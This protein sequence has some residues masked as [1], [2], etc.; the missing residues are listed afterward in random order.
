M[1][2]TKLNQKYSL[3]CG[4][5]ISAIKEPGLHFMINCIIDWELSGIITSDGEL[6]GP[7]EPK[8]IEDCFLDPGDCFCLGI[9]DDGTRMVLA[10]DK[11]NQVV[12]IVNDTGVLALRRVFEEQI[13]PEFELVKGDYSG[14]DELTWVSK[15]MATDYPTV[16]MRAL[17]ISKSKYRLWRKRFEEG[18][19]DIK[20]PEGF[21]IVS[22]RG[23]NTMGQ[24]VKLYFD[25]YTIRVPEDGS[26]FLEI[27]GLLEEISNQALAWMYNEI[28]VCKP[29][30]PA[31][32]ENKEKEGEP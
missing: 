13:K 7:G 16:D 12:C 31:P 10:M 26:L 11:D 15:N 2:I 28:P 3:G 18:R 1:I 14:I 21:L 8:N 4:K 24:D 32:I 25:K 19:G 20:F 17:D 9:K 5:G 29:V 23:D 27:P 30:A 22:V 6:K